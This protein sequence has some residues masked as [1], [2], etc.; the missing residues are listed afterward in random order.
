MENENRKE[1]LCF[2]GA[3]V[4]YAV[5]FSEVVE[6]CTQLKVEKIPCLPEYFCG[7]CHYKGTIISIVAMD[8]LGKMAEAELKD[9]QDGSSRG[10]V[11][12]VVDSGQYQFGISIQG[13]PWISTLDGKKIEDITESLVPD[14]WKEKAVYQTEK[15][16]IC[17]LDLVKS[18]DALASQ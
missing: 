3:G 17:Q 1:L 10:S 12:I 4:A 8:R 13:E 5:E 18:A 16:I 15:E 7:I 11:I 14:R 2:A 9:A 6:I